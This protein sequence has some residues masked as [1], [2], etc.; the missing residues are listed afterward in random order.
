MLKSDYTAI[1]NYMTECMN[2]SAHDREHVYRVLYG[3]MDIA[4]SES[5]VDFDI[6]TAAC[7]LH[8]IGRAEQFANPKLCHAEVGSEK[9]YRFLLKLGWS[10]ERAKRVRDCVKTHR[11]RS[12]CPPESIE[13]KILFDS[14]KLDVAGAI[15]I[16]R[17]LFYRGQVGEPL[18]RLNPDGTVSDGGS[19]TEPSFFREYKFKLENLY[20]KFFTKRGKELAEG[21]RRAAVDFYNSLLSE[22]RSEYETGKK[23]LERVIENDKSDSYRP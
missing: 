9:A 17:T 10:E 7:L 13:A 16:A 2:D 3:A 6:L 21:R 22:V 14:D 18:Y 1:E 4:K 11:F 23:F 20:D 15:G 8:D 5:G 12:D 19:D